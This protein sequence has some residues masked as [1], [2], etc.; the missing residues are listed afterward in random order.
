MVVALRLV[1]SARLAT[2]LTERSPQRQPGQPGRATE[3]KGAPNKQVKPSQEKISS[4]GA[5]K[6]LSLARE[7]SSIYPRDKTTSHRPESPLSFLLPCRFGSLSVYRAQAI[8]VLMG[9]A[10]R[11]SK[12][13][14][15]DKS[16]RTVNA[17]EHA[18]NRL[19]QKSFRAYGRVL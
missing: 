18:T 15:S 16:P 12:Q 2:P 19:I 17:K 3:R 9:H 7:K 8:L 5:R 4:R 11:S 10:H 13:L 1:T 6:K 14:S